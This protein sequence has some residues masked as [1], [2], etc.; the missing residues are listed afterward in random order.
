MSSYLGISWK[1][2][3]F[4]G[5]PAKEKLNIQVEKVISPL[6]KNKPVLLFF[7]TNKITP[8][9]SKKGKP[10]TTTQAIKSAKLG[11]AF[12]DKTFRIHLAMK[13]FQCYEVDLT[14]IL[15]KE[16]PII[17][18]EK[19]PMLVAYDNLNK[20]MAKPLKSGNSSSVFAVMATVLK[21]G[22]I[23][24]MGLCKEASPHL[25]Q[26]YS[27]ERKIYKHN[28]KY[29]EFREAYNKKPSKSKKTKLDKGATILTELKAISTKAKSEIDK[30]IVKYKAKIV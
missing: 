25:Q 1:K 4:A 16:S 9:R 28:E 15:M 30:L 19:A 6:S 22:N 26:F 29:A 21:K 10:K 17:C 14:N 2:L 20:K 8:P 18:H 23:D 13:F 3:A 27:N 5:N 7:G 11:E 24:I 12:D